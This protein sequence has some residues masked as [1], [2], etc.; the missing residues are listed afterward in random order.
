MRKQL[1]LITTLLISVSV[2]ASTPTSLSPELKKDYD[3]FQRS[4]EDAVTMSGDKAKF[5]KE[6][7]NIETGLQKK[8]KAFDK[9][10]GQKLT[11]EGNQMALDIEMLEPLK[12]IAEG[13]ASKESCSNAEF[14]NELNNQSDAKAYEKLKEQITK[15]CR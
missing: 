7:K 5:L 3:E 2:F 10:E 9:K 11:A 15:L 13:N 12:I 1:G 14:I 6:F 4:Y 8:Y